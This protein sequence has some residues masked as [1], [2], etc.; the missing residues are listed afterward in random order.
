MRVI[1]D[2]IIASVQRANILPLTSKCNLDCSFCSH[3]FNPAEIEVYTISSR[4]IEEIEAS[5]ELLSPKE[6]I[7]IGE[8][9]S[10]IIEGEPFLHPNIRDILKSIRRRFPEIPLQITTNGTYLTEDNIDLLQA[11]SPIE[12]YVSLNSADPHK[13]SLLM[14][15]RRPEIAIKGIEHLAEAG[16]PYHGSLVAMPWV[17]GWDDIAE[18]IRYLDRNLASTIRVFIPGYTHLA[19]PSWPEPDI[20]RSEALTFVLKMRKMIDTPLLLEPPL[21]TDLIA[22]VVG[23]IRDSPASEADI[24]MGDRIVKVAGEKVTSRAEAFYR[25]KRL[26]DPT[27]ILEREGKEISIILNKELGESSGL[28]FENDIEPYLLNSLERIRA[29]YKQDEV[30]ALVASSSST[31]LRKIMQPLGIEVVE[32]KNR[33]FGGTISSAGLLVVDDFRATLREKIAD[34]KYPEVILVPSIA[35]DERGRDLRGESYL[36][37]AKEFDIIVELG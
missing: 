9:A 20:L 17:V 8:S 1:D 31:I 35:F 15:D 25:L 30:W 6:K 19:P 11:L 36:E 37:L 12:L 2:T 27:M 4:P 16:I 34:G 29:R 22:E 24:K 3:K 21:L 28:V 5:L 7:V 26:A 10:K 23:V 13:R 14:R 18:T 33:F 32:V